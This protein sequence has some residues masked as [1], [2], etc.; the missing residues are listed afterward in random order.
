[1]VGLSWLMVYLKVLMDVYRQYLTTV[2]EE[3]IIILSVFHQ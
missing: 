1:M 2:D 3:T